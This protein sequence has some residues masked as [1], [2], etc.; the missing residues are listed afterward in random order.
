[1][2]LNTLSSNTFTRNFSSTFTSF[3]TFSISAPSQFDF[4]LRYNFPTGGLFVTLV[5]LVDEG[6]AK[7]V[8]RTYQASYGSGHAWFHRL[9]L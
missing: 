9:V 3:S 4:D 6:R 5:G 8:N 1:M 2:Q 7:P